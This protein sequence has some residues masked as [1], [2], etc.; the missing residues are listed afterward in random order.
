MSCD[1]EEELDGD[2]PDED[3]EDDVDE[4]PAGREVVLVPDVVVM[5]LLVVDVEEVV[6][7]ISE[8]SRTSK[9]SHIQSINQ[10]RWFPSTNLR[11][12]IN[13]T[14]RAAWW[15]GYMNRV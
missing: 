5:L 6:D 12:H 9:L 1:P 8:G 7:E 13:Y 2:T 11:E 3:D 4:P 15:D 10:R 14:K